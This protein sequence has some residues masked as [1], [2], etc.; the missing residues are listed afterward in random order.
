MWLR[1]F[2]NWKFKANKLHLLSDCNTTVF[3]LAKKKAL[4]VCRFLPTRNR[5]QPAQIT[6]NAVEEENK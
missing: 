1:L 3:R 5:G 4:T 6:K 2:G